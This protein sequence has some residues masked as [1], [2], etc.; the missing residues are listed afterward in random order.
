MLDEHGCETLQTSERR[1][2][3]HH[4]SLLAVVLSGVF[5]LEPLWQVV[6]YLNGTQLPAAANGILYH[7]VELRTIEGSLA[8]FHLGV[9]ALLLAAGAKSLLGTSLLDGILA[10]FPNL[11]RADVLLLVGWVTE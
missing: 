11:V 2:V 8:V 3:Y 9:Q 10:L 1:T 7:E 6:V 5:Q 4:R